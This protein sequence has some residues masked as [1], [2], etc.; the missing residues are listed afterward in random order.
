MFTMK[1]LIPRISIYTTEFHFIVTNFG[2]RKIEF[3]VLKFVTTNFDTHFVT[4][5][6]LNTRRISSSGVQDCRFLD[7]SMYLLKLVVFI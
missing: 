2:T 6:Y 1:I 7:L 5:W 3:W 4:A